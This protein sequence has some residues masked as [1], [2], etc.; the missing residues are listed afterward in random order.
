MKSWRRHVSFAIAGILLLML[1][2]MASSLGQRALEAASSRSPQEIIR[3]IQLRLEGHP[4]LVALVGPTLRAVQIRYERPPPLGALPTLGKGQQAT[5]MAP[6]VP[7]KGTVVRV[8]TAFALE[9]AL[10]VAEPGTHIVIEPGLYRFSRTLQL[11]KDG[12]RDMPIVVS[13]IRPG[14]VQLEFSQVSGIRVDRPHWSFENLNIKGVCTDHDNCE[15]A[16]HVLGRGAF[17]VLRNNRIEDFNAH[18]KVNG[19]N[20]DWPDHGL[21][22][23]NSLTNASPRQTGNPVV[24]LDLVGAHQW[25]VQDNLVVGFAKGQGNRIAYGLFMKGASEGGR[26]ERNLVVCSPQQISHPGVRVGISFGGGGGNAEAICRQ[27]ACQDFQHRHGLAA[28]N[29]VAHC[30][31]AGIDVNASSDIV[32]AHNTLINTAGFLARGSPTQ[33]SLRGNHFEG[34]IAVRDHADVRSELNVFLEAE[35]NFLRM[36]A[37]L[38]RWV[39]PPA[40]IPMTGFVTDDFNKARRIFMTLPGAIEAPSWGF[41]A[42]T[43]R[44]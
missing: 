36:D 26:I 32:L 6:A 5:S 15:H 30:N 39:Q 14:S 34:T 13:A 44:N 25:R 1:A 8:R 41:Q 18:I 11:G 28:N 12:H 17:V 29:I 22:A 20:G 16:F 9:Q 2:S 21:V 37:L 4:W 40:P 33:V 7:I 10:L 38:L 24:M 27:N 23:F 35:Q 31:D 19:L 3:Y 43:G 42:P